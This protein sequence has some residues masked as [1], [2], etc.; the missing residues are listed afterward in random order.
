MFNFWLFSFEDVAVRFQVWGQYVLQSSELHFSGWHW[1]FSDRPTPGSVR[2][3]NEVKYAKLQ[4]C[5]SYQLFHK[6][7]GIHGHWYEHS[8]RVIMCF[9]IFAATMSIFQNKQTFGFNHL[10]HHYESTSPNR[11]SLSKPS[12]PISHLL[13]WASSF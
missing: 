1:N 5:M 11:F 8:F 12:W 9:Y 6:H 3:F 4:S 7:T 10:T 13:T 2:Q